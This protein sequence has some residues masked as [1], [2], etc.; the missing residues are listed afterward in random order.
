MKLNVLLAI[1]AI[2]L[3]LAGLGFLFAPTGIM[4]GTVEAGASAA[5]IANLRGPASTVI[6]I[7]VL[8]WIARNAEASKA[9]DAIILANTIGFGL[10]GI[11]DVLA[12]LSGAPT[13]ELVPAVIN[14]LIA[15]AFFWA[16]R[17]SMSAKT[18]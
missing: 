17:A 1:S 9:R 3:A 5:L 14:L 15:V 10:A 11:L 12:V 18:S 8:N 6:A 16:G 7:A 13:I 2:Y 4:F